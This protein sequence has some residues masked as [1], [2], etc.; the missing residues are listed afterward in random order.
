MAAIYRTHAGRLLYA[1]IRCSGI[2]LEDRAEMNFRELGL[3][4]FRE[5]RELV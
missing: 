1:L 2:L 5:T 4:T 3:V